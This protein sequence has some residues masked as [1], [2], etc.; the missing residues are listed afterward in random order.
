MISVNGHIIEPTKFPDGTS[1]VWKIPEEV[2]QGSRYNVLFIFEDESEVFQLIQLN[3]LLKYSQVPRPTS[4]YMP[5]LPYSRQD[6]GVDNQSTFALHC[7]ADIVNRMRFDEVSTI[8]VHSK[9][10]NELFDS[11]KNIEPDEPI[12][13]ARR[14]LTCFE[15]GCEDNLLLATPDAGAADRYAK[16]S[17]SVV[18]HK[19]RDQSTGWITDYEVEGDPEGKDILIIDD[20]CDGGMTFKLFAKELL[21]QGANS[22]N[23]YVT[24]GIFSKGLQT[25]KDAG[26]SKIFTKDGE[27]T[28]E[29]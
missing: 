27:V 16:Y 23:L 9:V 7:F 14:V 17:I 15:T 24:H 20:I 2:F 3:T 1:Q 21:T 8:D 25:L 18:G 10:A 11:F 12:N 29:K 28:E 13:Q 6:K 26:I 22:V 19:V 5:F 4:L